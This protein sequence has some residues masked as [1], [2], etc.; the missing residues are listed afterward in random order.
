MI[1]SAE[2]FVALRTSEDPEEYNRAAHDEA[3]EEVWWDVIR[4][5]LVMRKQAR[6]LALRTIALRHS[7]ASMRV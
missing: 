5:F 2:E 1:A 6:L 7:Q 3:P 4:R